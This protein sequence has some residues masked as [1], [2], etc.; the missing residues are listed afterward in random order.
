VAGV[1]LNS[2]SAVTDDISVASNAGELA[3]RCGVPLLA[4]VEYG[5]RF[6]RQVDWMALAKITPY[7]AL[8]T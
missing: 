5:G 2:P 3:R 4:T 1:V 6:D 8:S 7:T